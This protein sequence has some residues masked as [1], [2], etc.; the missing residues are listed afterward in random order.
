MKFFSQLTFYSVF[1]DFFVAETNAVVCLAELIAF[2]SIFDSFFFQATWTDV[3]LNQTWYNLYQ[4]IHGIS[5]HDCSERNLCVERFT[6][7]SDFADYIWKP[8]FYFQVK[9][10]SMNKFMV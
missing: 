3:R 10:I 5:Y 4:N 7:G 1:Y 2:F 9:F 8:D 6:L